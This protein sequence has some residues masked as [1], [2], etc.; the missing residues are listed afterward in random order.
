MEI[1]IDAFVS[2]IFSDQLVFFHIF[3]EKTIPQEATVWSSS[4]R[5]IA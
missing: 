4:Q 2:L 5:G 3:A 1:T